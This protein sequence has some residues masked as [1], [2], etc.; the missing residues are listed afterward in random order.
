MN[1]H[2]HWLKTALDAYGITK[3]MIHEKG[4]NYLMRCS[5]CQHTYTL[6]RDRERYDYNL[7]DTSDVRQLYEFSVS[8]GYRES[9]EFDALSVIWRLVSLWDEIRECSNDSHGR[10]QSTS[11]A[12]VKADIH[13]YPVIDLFFRK[14]MGCCEDIC[15]QGKVLLTCDLDR[16]YKYGFS[17]PIG[18]VLALLRSAK[19]RFNSFPVYYSANSIDLTLLDHNFERFFVKDIDGIPCARPVFFFIPSNTS[20]R[21]DGDSIVTGCLAHEIIKEIK[22]RGGECGFHPGYFFDDS[23]VRLPYVQGCGTITRYHYLRFRHPSSALNLE[24]L[25]VQQ[26][27]SLGFCDRI[28]FRRGS[29]VPLK[30]PFFNRRGFSTV[31]YLETFLMDVSL[32]RELGSGHYSLNSMLPEW[33]WPTGELVVLSHNNNETLVW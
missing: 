26:D 4:G 3:F 16:F 21:F 10:P 19:N 7:S 33:W 6:G 25:R 23:E 14:L 8:T 24:K 27:F 29:T 20:I 17:S 13:K 12:L 11:N 15:S 1:Y 2:I 32:T 5:K 28:G 31:D 18:F 22:I 9:I 30:L